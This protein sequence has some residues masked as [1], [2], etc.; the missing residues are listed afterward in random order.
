MIGSNGLNLTRCAEELNELP[1][2]DSSKERI[3]RRNALES[4]GL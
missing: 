1:L 2:R 4:P 3:L